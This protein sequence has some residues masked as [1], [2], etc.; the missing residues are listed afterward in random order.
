MPDKKP[1][2]KLLRDIYND[3]AEINFRFRLYLDAKVDYEE[4]FGKQI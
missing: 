3:I 2:I 4:K 1:D